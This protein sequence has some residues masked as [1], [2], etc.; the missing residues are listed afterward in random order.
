MRLPPAARA[1]VLTPVE[2]PL[3]NKEK[4]ERLLE[5]MR[6]DWDERAAQDAEH[7]VYTR[8]SN[9][10][11]DDFEASGRVNYDQMVRP[12]LPVLLN[13]RSPSCCRVVE[14]GCGVGR[15]TRSFAEEFL[16]V[17]G[18]DVSPRM[19][20]QT[21]SRLRDYPNVILHVGSGKDL[22]RLP[23]S[24]FDLAFSYL[25]FQHIPSREVIESYIRE[26]ARVLKPEGAF[27]FQLNGYLAPDYRRQEKDTWLGESFS[28]A[29]AAQML[30]A[31]GFS[32]LDASGAGTQYFMLNAR[33]IPDGARPFTT[34]V[35]SGQ[36]WARGQLLEGWN[37]M[38]SGG[39]WPIEP[40]SRAI[41][42]VPAAPQLRV[43]LS[44]YV[45]AV[46]P[47]PAR[48]L[49]ASLNEVPLGSAP[50]GREQDQY[51]EWTVP[52]GAVTGSRAVLTLEFHPPERTVLPRVRAL[53][54]YAPREA[55][56]RGEDP[57]AVTFRRLQR[58]HREAVAWARE[59]EA[60]LQQADQTQKLDAEP[61]APRRALRPL[62]A[63]L[64]FWVGKKLRLSPVPPSDQERGGGA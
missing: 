47:F 23:D 16:E 51:F 48:T 12:Y 42:V 53:G 9:S 43:F 55:E 14:I 21:R 37:D 56:Q 45:P 11:E 61:E 8:D 44:L 35:Y 1:A 58:E 26:A 49:K 30:T 39:G 62:F 54:I 22:G 59:L 13:G 4:F 5:R 18:I 41:F 57:A 52:A 6:R 20:E 64:W 28:L 31:A 29:E 7:Y 34:H 10:D 17:H 33:K 46:A 40:V 36:G 25:V 19:I 15:I 50:L 27:R 38:D 60:Q 32:P 24:Y 2:S 3:S 63:S